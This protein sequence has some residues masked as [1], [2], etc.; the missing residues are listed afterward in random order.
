M[1]H[2][3]GALPA[4]PGGDVPK[5]LMKIHGFSL[6]RKKLSGYAGN[7]EFLKTP[8]RKN[9]G[10]APAPLPVF[11]PPLNSACNDRTIVKT[12]FAL[13]MGSVGLLW[14]GRMRM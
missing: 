8:D 7:S 3:T 5:C 1:D 12:T 10:S 6:L 9:A 2:E 13:L 11:S 14:G 4:E